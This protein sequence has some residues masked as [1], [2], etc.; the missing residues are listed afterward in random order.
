MPIEGGPPKLL[1]KGGTTGGVDVAGNRIVFIRQ[2][3]LAPADGWQMS[4]HS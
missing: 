3:L 1:A 2:S 4:L